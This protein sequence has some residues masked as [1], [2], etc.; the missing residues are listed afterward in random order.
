VECPKAVIAAVPVAVCIG[1]TSA[2]CRPRPTPATDVEPVSVKVLIKREHD[3][4]KVPLAPPAP[5]RSV[6]VTTS[7]VA[8][9]C[10]VD[11]IRIGLMCW[12]R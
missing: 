5:S 9:P 7:P 1:A 4:Q 2:I 12:P 6:M 10:A 8:S 3:D 11:V